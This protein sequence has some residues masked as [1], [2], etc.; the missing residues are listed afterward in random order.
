MS[1][2]PATRIAEGLMGDAIYA[3]PMLLGFAWQ[4]GWIPVGRRAIE[5]AIELNAVAVDSNLAAFEWGRRLAQWPER[6]RALAGLDEPGAAS[7][8]PV[9]GEDESLESLVEPRA[10]FLVG[11]QDAAY[12]QRYRALVDKVAR[13]EREIS[14]DAGLPLARAVAKSWFRLLA[15]KDEY[16]VARLHT[17]PAFR[18]RLDETFEGDWKPRLHLAPPLL[19]R[20]DPRTGRPRKIAFGPWI[21]LVLRVLAHGKH[22]RGTRF[23]PFGRLAE[24]RI[25]RALIDEYEQLLEVEILPGLDADRLRLAVE[26]ASLPLSIRGFGPVKARA[27]E[28]AA[29]RRGALLARWRTGLALAPAAPDGDNPPGGARRPERAAAAMAESD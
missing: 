24:R 6:V 4:R 9:A 12:A 26:I 10:E 14:G 22:L 25:E 23:D 5:R 17:D 3:N 16:E 18:K 19:S 8:S 28:E 7:Q 15:Y 21:L 27:L 29:T 11:Y 13:R 20:T 2:V 1:F